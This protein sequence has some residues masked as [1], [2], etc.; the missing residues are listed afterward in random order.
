MTLLNYSAFHGSTKLELS[1]SQVGLILCLG[2]F[3]M[4]QAVQH[5][6]FQSGQTWPFPPQKKKKSIFSL[7]PLIPQIDDIQI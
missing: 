1:F 3:Q 2:A 5:V 6:Y 7:V 4:D